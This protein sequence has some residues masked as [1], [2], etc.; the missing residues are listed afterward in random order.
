MNAITEIITQLFAKPVTHKG[1][2]LTS[3]YVLVKMMEM[4]HPDN[5]HHMGE[6]VFTHTEDVWN[7]AFKDGGFPGH[8]EDWDKALKYIIVL[9]DVGKLFAR[10][11]HEEDGRITFYDHHKDSA[12]IASLVMENVSFVNT[13]WK[14]WVVDIVRLHDAPFML[15]NNRREGLSHM[16]KFMR[17]EVP[18]SDTMLYLLIVLGRADCSPRF[19]HKKQECMER[20]EKDLA[21][22][23][24]EERNRQEKAAATE[25]RFRE[26]KPE[27][28]ELL[29]HLGPQAITIVSNAETPKDIGRLFGELGKNKQQDI[30]KKVKA[31][32]E[33]N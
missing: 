8:S 9:H 6:S 22:W 20:F 16:K 10:E 19:F 21:A 17:E 12:S 1:V 5:D 30:I 3:N 23:R 25:A 26:V 31:L 33:V 7:H 11:E 14:K 29:G 2:E 13:D 27:I 28:A 15:D 24:Q 18:Q 32:Y 4:Y